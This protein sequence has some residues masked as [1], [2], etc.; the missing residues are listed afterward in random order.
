MSSEFSGFLSKMGPA[1]A[2]GWRGKGGIR[3]P[4][5]RAGTVY[6][7]IKYRTLYLLYF[8]WFFGPFALL[9]LCLLCF[10][11]VIFEL[12]DALDSTPWLCL[13]IQEILLLR[14]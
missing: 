13:Y 5:G 3:E 8:E 10:V 6:K 1:S 2:I 14:E 4:Q 7:R 12:M 9:Y 11:F